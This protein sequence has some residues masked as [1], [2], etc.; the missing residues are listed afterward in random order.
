MSKALD[1]LTKSLLNRKPSMSVTVVTKKS[2]PMDSLE[3][4]LDSMGCSPDDKKNIM[5]VMEKYK[6]DGG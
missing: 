1:E 3:K 2:G 5:G 6:K 4:S